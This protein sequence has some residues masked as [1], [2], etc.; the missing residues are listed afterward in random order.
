MRKVLVFLPLL[1]LLTCSCQ[2]L[3]APGAT[4]QAVSTPIEPIV[5]AGRGG[6]VTGTVAQVQ[7]NA[8][9][10]R[11]IRGNVLVL[12]RDGAA[13]SKLVP[14]AAGDLTPGAQASVRGRRNDA[15]AYEALSVNVT[16]AGLH[17][18]DSGTA[19]AFGFSSAADPPLAGKVQAVSSN[20]FTLQTDAGTVAV[21]VTSNTHLSK[22]L[23]AVLGELREGQR[24][25]AGGDVNVDGSLGANEFEI[26]TPASP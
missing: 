9:T 19:R 11:T 26:L 15:G 10:L 25:V 4:P 17:V 12:L 23:P 6:V 14:A 22:A 2:G 1:A 16:S 24:A 21:V 7:G 8:L 13:M 5:R 18:P 20:G 3:P